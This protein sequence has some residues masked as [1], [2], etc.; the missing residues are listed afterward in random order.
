MTRLTLLHV[1]VI[2]LK[3]YDQS[4]SDISLLSSQLTCV[5]LLPL[6]QVVWAG[7]GLQRASVGSV[8]PKSGGSI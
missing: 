2:W 6:F 1:H 8:G 7:E 5:C 4:D 3:F